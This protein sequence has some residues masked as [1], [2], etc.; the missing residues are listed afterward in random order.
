MLSL[1]IHRNS[2]FIKFQC[3]MYSIWM[4]CNNLHNIMA[5]KRKWSNYVLNHQQQTYDPYHIFHLDKHFE[6]ITINNTEMIFTMSQVWNL[7]SNE[8]VLWIINS[9]YWYCLFE[10]LQVTKQY[11][12][13]HSSCLNNLYVTTLFLIYNSINATAHYR[14]SCLFKVKTDINIICKYQN[15][16]KFFINNLIIHW[17]ERIELIMRIE[18][19]KIWLRKNYGNTDI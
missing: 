12:I 18:S 4:C 16:V 8:Y 11:S 13:V 10:I 6:N 5:M 15:A 1:K 19:H 3:N 9:S 17:N 7:F 14:T 2:Y